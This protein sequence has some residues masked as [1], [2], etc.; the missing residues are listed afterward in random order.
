MNSDNA[1]DH[2]L[3]AAR[4]KHLGAAVSRLSLRQLTF[5]SILV[6]LIT[7]V[8]P[9]L[10]VG[11]W[12]HDTFVTHPSLWAVPTSIKTYK[13]TAKR[14]K[15]ARRVA[16]AQY[17]NNPLTVAQF[18]IVWNWSGG[19]DGTY[20]DIHWDHSTG[21][22]N[23]SNPAN[24]YQ[25]GLT[26]CLGWR[27]GGFERWTYDWNDDR[28]ARLYQYAGNSATT[29]KWTYSSTEACFKDT[30]NPTRSPSWPASQAAAGVYFPNVPA[31]REYWFV[32]MSVYDATYTDAAGSHCRPAINIQPDSSSAAGTLPTNDSRAT[33]TGGYIAVYRQRD[34][35]GG[36]YNGARE[37]RQDYCTDF[38]KAPR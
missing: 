17:P 19:G 26:N 12:G 1:C 32:P 10:A 14:L 15:V 25:L 6:L 24:C 33:S 13:Y 28:S 18:P 8:T 30:M 36:L 7:P 23:S 29:A 20:R 37:T 4:S 31:D 9:S 5:P 16:T 21:G 3:S 27:T 2:A 35:N 22:P 34:G 38:F 11:N